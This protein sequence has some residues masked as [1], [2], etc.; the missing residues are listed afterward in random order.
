MK[1]R[2]LRSGRVTAGQI[3]PPVGLVVVNVVQRIRDGAAV[4]VAARSTQLVQVVIIGQAAVRVTPDALMG[5]SLAGA[6]G[7][8]G[9]NG[10]SYR[11]ELVASLKG[12]RHIGSVLNESSD[13]VVADSLTMDTAVTVGLSR[14]ARRS[15]RG[16]DSLVKEIQMLIYIIK[17]LRWVSMRDYYQHYLPLWVS[18]W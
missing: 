16:A 4:E 18:R 8:G 6:V 13:E 11:A 9:G 17:E 1:T 12:Y 10:E 2:P 7:K 5:Y 15:I 3:E 14:R